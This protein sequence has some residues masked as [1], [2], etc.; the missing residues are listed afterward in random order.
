M[1]PNGCFSMCVLWQSCVFVFCA[2]H[3]HQVHF[4]YSKTQVQRMQY[5]VL[6]CVLDIKNSSNADLHIP[7]PREVP[8]FIAARPSKYVLVRLPG[9]TSLHKNVSPKRNSR[10]SVISTLMCFEGGVALERREGGIS[11]P[12]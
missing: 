12:R 5:R 9:K 8:E 1:R 11:L 4:Q 2:L 10:S 3:H 6:E 7:N